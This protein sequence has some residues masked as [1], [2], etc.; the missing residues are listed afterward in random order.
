M[1]QKFVAEYY[2]LKL[3]DLKSRNNS[4]SVAVPRQVAMYLCKRLTNASLPEIGKSFGGKHHSTVIHSVRKV[5]ELRK[6]DTAF[7]TTVNSLLESFR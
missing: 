4:K 7:N 1:I 2:Q 3:V 5:E 6:Q